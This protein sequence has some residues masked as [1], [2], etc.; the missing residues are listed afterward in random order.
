M[1]IIHKENNGIVCITIIGRMGAELA[2]ELEKVI[3]AIAKER[4]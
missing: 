3:K 2:P 1:E 4:R